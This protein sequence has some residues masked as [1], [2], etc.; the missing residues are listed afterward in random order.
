MRETIDDEGDFFFCNS[1]NNDEN[2][3]YN[4]QPYFEQPIQD[5]QNFGL[6]DLV[7]LWCCLKLFFV[8]VKHLILTLLFVLSCLYETLCMRCLT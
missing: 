6:N 5:N 2:V 3:V 1:T 8:Y 7:C 4:D